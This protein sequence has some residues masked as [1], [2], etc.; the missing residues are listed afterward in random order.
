MPSGRPL[1]YF[2]PEIRDRRL[3]KPWDD[4]VK[5]ALYF[6]G[7]DGITRQFRRQS[8]YGGHLTE[9]VVQAMARDLMA[10]GMLR[11]R[12]KGY[13][14]ILTV[15]DEVLVQVPSAEADIDTFLDIVT[16][17]PRW[18]EGLPVAGEAWQGERYRK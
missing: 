10:G 13:T 1:A 12:S 16:T 14:P 5:P 7:V 6:Y 15:H 18:A 4:V 8:S 11:L 3:P 17:V 9:N 2:N